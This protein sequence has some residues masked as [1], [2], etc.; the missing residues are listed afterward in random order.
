LYIQGSPVEIAADSNSLE[1][2]RTQYDLWYRPVVFFL[3]LH[4]IA[5]SFPQRKSRLAF[6][7]ML[8]HFFLYFKT[9]TRLRLRNAE[10]CK[11]E[12][13]CFYI[14]YIYV[15]IYMQC[16]LHMHVGASRDSLTTH[17]PTPC[18]RA[19]S[20]AAKMNGIQIIVEVCYGLWFLFSGTY[21]AAV[22][23]SFVVDASEV[24]S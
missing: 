5:L 11:L 22:L 4:L 24:R 16:T 23:F 19:S 8:F 1:L 7:K 15:F 21:C 2:V 12:S 13:V 10:M 9:F 17:R 3:H 18:F 6:Q 20:V 14:F